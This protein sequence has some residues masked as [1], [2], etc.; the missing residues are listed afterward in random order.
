M[1]LGPPPSVHPPTLTRSRPLSPSCIYSST[2][3]YIVDANN[4]R[5]S[6]AVATN[7]A[8][9][10]LSAFV[11]AEVAVPLQLAIGDG[12]TYSLWAGLVLL[13]ELLILLVWWRG[14][15]WREKWE[16]VERGLLQS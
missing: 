7:S 2:L 5:S 16:L 8:F 11:A 4:G 12:G 13:S 15:A 10:G 6:S 1:S 14:G 9:R 3:A